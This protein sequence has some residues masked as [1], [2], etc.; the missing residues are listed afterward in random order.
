MF[1][2]SQNGQNF[3][4]TPTQKNA[5]PDVAPGLGGLAAN[6][7]PN[8]PSPNSQN[9]AP[10]A[11]EVAPIQSQERLS[12]PET[13]TGPGQ[14]QSPQDQTAAPVQQPVVIPTA[15]PISD[16]QTTSTSN[17]AAAADED[18][19][20]KEW[21]DQAKTIV[22]KTKGD[23]HEQARMVAELMRD[24]VKKRYGKIIGKTAE[25]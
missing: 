9:I 19:I 7:N 8:S 3:N 10:T 13:Q 4:A 15:A 25:D 24:Y 20:E 17:P 2:N 12:N 6:M 5:Q 14:S 21:V 18:L 22:S 23:P 16:D 1:P 11:P